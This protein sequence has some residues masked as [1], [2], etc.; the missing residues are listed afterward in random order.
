MRVWQQVK[1]KG[2]GDDRT[3]WA[4]VVVATNTDDLEHVAVKWDANGITEL[5]PV[6]ELQAL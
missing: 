4:G 5:V 6:T 1:F 3:G 2:E